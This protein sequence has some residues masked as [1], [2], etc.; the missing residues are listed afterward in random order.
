MRKAIIPF[1]LL[2]LLLA[3]CG[4][5]AEL[6]SCRSV[7]DTFMERLAKGDQL[8]AYELCD[9]NALSMDNLRSIANNPDF[10]EMLNDYKGLEHGDG[11]QKEDKDSGDE[12]RLAPA[13]ATGHENFI[14]HFAFRKEP[15]GWRII[16]F[17]I[18]RK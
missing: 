14:V 17:K 1:L 8:G 3:G 2:T 6:A 9:P 18:E 11:G 16:G 15:A 7:A 10:S 12:V 5:G 4:P 13:K